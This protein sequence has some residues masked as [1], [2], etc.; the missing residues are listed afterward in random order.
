MPLK[1]AVQSRAERA[2]G[3]LRLG[4][5]NCNPLKIRS[6]KRFTLKIPPTKFT[7]VFG[8]EAL[9]NQCKLVE[10]VCCTEK[11]VFLQQE[12]RGNQRLSVSLS[13]CKI[14]KK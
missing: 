12:Q 10:G 1:T 6:A 3:S 11:N 14:L 13:L 8:E 5:V 4:T 7:A 2:G 9:R